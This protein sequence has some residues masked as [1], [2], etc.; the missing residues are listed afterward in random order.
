MRKRLSILCIIFGAVLLCAALLLFLFNQRQNQQAEQS[1]QTAVEQVQQQIAVRQDTAAENGETP[2]EAETAE[3]TETT[4]AVDGEDYIGYISIPAIGIELPVMSDWSYPKLRKA[5][6]RQF[7]SAETD[8]LVIAAHNYA[9]HF[10]HLK[11]LSTGDSITFTAA[12]GTVYTYTVSAIE[13]LEPTAVD[14]VQFS[15]H[16][17]VLYSCTYGGK[18]RV[19]VFADKTA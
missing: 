15:G 19:A 7:G 3:A 5:P 17:L 18:T 4:V 12:D 2:P 9:S 1:A 16:D 13:I 14:E 10:G 11:D 6:C 8:D